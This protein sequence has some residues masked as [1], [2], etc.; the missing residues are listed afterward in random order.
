[1]QY[2][3]QFEKGESRT[4]HLQAFLRFSTSVDFGRA[5][6]LFGSERGHIEKCFN[7]SKAEAYC[8]KEETR[9]A[10]PVSNIDQK[11]FSGGQGRRTDLQEVAEKTKAGTSLARIAEEH[12]TTFIKFHRGEMHGILMVRQVPY[13]HSAS[14]RSLGFGTR[15]VWKHL[16]CVLGIKELGAIL[17]PRRSYK[18][19]VWWLYGPPG[20]GKSRLAREP[21]ALYGTG[22]SCDEHV[23]SKSGGSK[24]WDGYSA[25]PVVVWDEPNGEIEWG[26]LLQLC[27]R[28]EYRVE[29]K[30]G[31]TQFLS[32][33]II[34]TSNYHP[35]T[36]FAKHSNY[37][38]FA[39]RITLLLEFTGAIYVDIKEC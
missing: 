9:V 2:T 10:G 27:D 29:V 32:R 20:I 25:Q 36:L 26:G 5:K 15:C 30:G 13:G 24:W 4:T 39:R 6:A 38:A 8:R 31:M 37:S 18:T 21:A 22:A 35:D 17:S 23:Y 34:F 3:G 28:Y 1:M 19:V 11:T 14:L 7:V 12:P 16:V 33:L